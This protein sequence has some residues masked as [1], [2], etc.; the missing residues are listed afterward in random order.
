MRGIIRW[1]FRGLV[2]L[3]VLLLLAI[4]GVWYLASRSLPDYDRTVTVATPDGKP[5]TIIRDANAIPH[6]TAS[7]ELGVF[8]GLGYAHAQDRL[9]QMLQMRRAAQG[10]LSEIFGEVTL[11]IDV[12]LRRLGLYEA[13]RKSFEVQSPEAK[14]ALVAYAA[15]VNARLDVVNREAL[16]R[17][18]P[19]LFLFP[20]TIA[21]W[22]PADSIAII[23]LM[24][25][26]LAPHMDDEILRARLARILPAPRIDDLLAPAPGPATTTVGSYA[27]LFGDNVRFAAAA[28]APLPA[29]LPFDPTPA[30]GLAGASNAWIAAPSRTARG[31]S[32]LAND[33]HLGLSAPAIW[34]LA[35]LDFPDGGVIGGT[36]PGLPAVLVG[37]K[38]TVAWGLTYAYIDDTDLYIEKLGKDPDTYLTPEGWKRFR[39]ARTR[40]RVK[41][42]KD[43]ELTLRWSENGPILPNDRFGL[44]S[45]VPEGH[46]AALRWTALAEDDH[47]YTAT[48]GLMKANSVREAIEATRPFNAPAQNLSLADAN[49][50]GIKIIGRIPKRNPAHQTR[51]MMPAPGWVKENRWEGYFPYEDNLEVI[52]PPEGVIANTNNKTVDAPFPRHVSYIWGDS[53]RIERAKKLLGRQKAHTLESFIATQTDIVSN[54]ARTLLPLVMRDLPLTAPPDADARTRRRT[55]ALRLL[56]AWE[57]AMDENRPEPLI[58]AAWM[59][60]LQARLLSDELG[61]LA[62]EFLHLKPL[63]V[64]R[65]FRNL[66]GAGIWCDV[67]GTK[68]IETCAGIAAASLDEALDWITARQGSDMAGWE[69]GREHMAALDHQVL[70]KLPLVGALFN[71]RLPSSGGDETL[72]RG[73]TA[74]KG[75]D[76][77]LNVHASAYRGVY[78]FADPES[79]RFI[80]STG[81]S[82]HPLS[83]FYDNFARPWKR[84]EYV[85]MSMDLDLARAGGV[86]VTRLVPQGEEE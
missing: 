86:G 46:V 16:G 11:P 9:W 62:E 8:F 38:K 48:Y 84:G 5:V 6:I 35:H 50:I 65:V 31:K 76:P 23:K 51:G 7:S 47:S 36:I 39:T 33:P 32:L 80:I 77:F 85:P 78:D 21:P 59:R 73:R 61:P 10:R 34:Y 13:A 44:A 53:H 30:P 58:Y 24:A 64:E 69:W 4:A 74:G 49:D 72:M 2:A 27:R 29:R 75:P 60:F 14:A 15:G 67:K 71:I 55:E 66:G 56:A 81:E 70:G 37:R 19:E 82:G 45:V 25:L 83:R 20:Q 17:G 54:A 41:G 57:G 26:R 28:D 22:T 12:Y 1:S 18:A 68:E 3:L 79:S 52:N 63:F 42:G 43:V 40:I